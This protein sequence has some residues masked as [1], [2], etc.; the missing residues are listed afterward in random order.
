MNCDDKKTV[1]CHISVISS[2]LRH[3]NKALD[4]YFPEFEED[5][6]ILDNLITDIYCRLEEIECTLNVWNACGD[7][8]SCG[9]AP[10]S[11]GGT[12]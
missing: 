4:V 12:A 3:I 8:A 5:G 10:T 2:N 6:T 9:C 7:D 1:A 11:Y